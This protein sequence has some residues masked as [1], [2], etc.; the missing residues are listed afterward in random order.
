MIKNINL[1]FSF[2][3]LSIV[4]LTLIPV[5]YSEYDNHYEQVLY[6]GF[7]TVPLY[8]FCLGIYFLILIFDFN[9]FVKKR[10]IKA[11]LPSIVGMLLILF[12]VFFY[13]FHQFK[14][15]RKTTL[16][17]YSN[18]IDLK[19]T[20][21]KYII[22]FKTNNTFVVYELEEEGLLTS[23]YYCSFI[24]KDSI[25]SLDSKFGK[26]KISSTFLV[27]SVKIKNKTEQQFI[28]IDENGDEIKS[29]FH[30]K[31]KNMNSTKNSKK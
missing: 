9:L 29:Q 3:R 7:I 11:L 30:F 22:E 16:K 12:S 5:A 20:N 31:I 23:F 8:A 13:K 15:Y 1:G 14:I 2:I 19:G 27:R 18:W 28:Q 26:N 17:A 4:L 21:F 25:Y 6:S 10:K 24:K